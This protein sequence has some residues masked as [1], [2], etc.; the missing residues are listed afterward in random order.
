MAKADRLAAAFDYVV[1]RASKKLPWLKGVK[2][3]FCN[4][5][6]AEHRRKWRQFMHS[7]DRRMTVCAA[8]VAETLLTD[9]ELVGMFAHELGHVVGAELGFPEH[10]KSQRGSGT[11][12][13]VQR[14]ADWIAR[15]VL[16]FKT[17]RYNRRTLQE[18]R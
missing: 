8:R 13:P 15:N 3:R 10:A 6:D 17:L 16:G 4:G 7:G 18:A 5:A 11:P 12:K 2:L 14:E 1:R 9:K